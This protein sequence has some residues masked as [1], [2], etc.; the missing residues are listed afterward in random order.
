MPNGK[1]GLGR[2]ARRWRSKKIVLGN[3]TDQYSLIHE[4]FDKISHTAYAI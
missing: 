2:P 1:N 4:A 3:R